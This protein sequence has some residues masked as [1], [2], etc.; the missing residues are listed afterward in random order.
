M[1]PTTSRRGKKAEGLAGLFSGLCF[2]WSTK[3]I[4]ATITMDL[5]AVLFGGATALLPI[6]AD[7]ILH[8]GPAGLGW[9]RAAPSVGAICMA[10]TLAHRPPHAAARAGDALRRGR[11]SGWS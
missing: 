5:F 1:R 9:L 7:Q 2:V 3:I 4:L 10:I 8:V 6:Y 11:V